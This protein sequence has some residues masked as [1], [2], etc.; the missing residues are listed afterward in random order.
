MADGRGVPPIDPTRLSMRAGDAVQSGYS[1]KQLRGSGWIKPFTGVVRPADA[2][3]EPV[4]LRLSDAIALLTPGCV[5]G[6]WAALA[7]QGNLWFSGQQRD[8]AE[9]DVLVHCLPGAQLRRRA[10]V[11][12]F[13]GLLHPDEAIDLEHVTVTTIARSA[14]DEMCVA[15]S[16]REAVVALDLSVTTTAQ[17]P[18]TSI[19]AVER[20]VSV[21][22][23]VRG[24]VRARRALALAS[25]RSA[26]PWETRTRL[27]AELDAGITGLLVNVPVFDLGGRL[28]GVADLLDEATGLVIESD[29]A[30][31]REAERHTDDNRREERFE[32]AGMVVCRVTSLDHG[33]RFGTAARLTAGRGDAARSARRA[34]TL[35]KPD[36][37]WRWASG[38][39]WD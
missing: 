8:G 5:L 4:M 6:G 21:H 17:V 7:M 23:K 34:W 18:H 30:D 1:R 26:S 32:R 2:E 14:F 37:W 24:L 29:G 15:G 11:R 9:R 31:H 3:A 25:S 27:L 13:R 10:G 12:P 38:R 36:W 19:A 33:D 16:V 20:V 22:H 39:R 35:E 28:L